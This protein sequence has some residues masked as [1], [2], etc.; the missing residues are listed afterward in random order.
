M[1]QT[2]SESA[3]LCCVLAIFVNYNLQNQ[4]NAIFNANKP[5]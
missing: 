5:A 1:E 3:L 4:K 2:Q